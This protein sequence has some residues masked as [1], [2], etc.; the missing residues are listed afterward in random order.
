MGQVWGIGWMGKAVIFSSSRN[1]VTMAALC[2]GALSWRSLAYVLKSIL[3]PTFLK[4]RLKLLFFQ[5]VIPLE[6]KNKKKKKKK[7]Q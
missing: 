1:F 4:T 2:E 5:H 6:K 7:K 3:R